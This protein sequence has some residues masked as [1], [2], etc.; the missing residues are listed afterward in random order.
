MILIDR[1][2]YLPLA[3]AESLAEKGRITMD[4]IRFYKSNTWRK[5]RE[6]VLI[7]DRY[8]CQRCLEEGKLTPATTVHHKQHLKDRP[9][10]ALSADNLQSVCYSCHNKLHPEKARRITKRKKKTNTEAT[11][12]RRAR[13]IESKP[14]PEIF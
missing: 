6:Y 5:C 1:T 14:N 13:V 3:Y 4:T 12:K 2:S 9:D 10:L 7:R 11:T 8:L